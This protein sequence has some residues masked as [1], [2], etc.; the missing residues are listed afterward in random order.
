MSERTYAGMTRAEIH[1]AKASEAIPELLEHIDELEDQCK[2]DGETN[3]MLRNRVRE[4]E[5]A[6][7][8]S[9]NARLQALQRMSETIREI[10]SSL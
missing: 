1:P 8:T 3:D 10:R 9:E 4:L 5:I 2:D 7:A 6:L